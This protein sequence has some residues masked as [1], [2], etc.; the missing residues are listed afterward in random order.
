MARGAGMARPASSSVP[1]QTPRSRLTDL[2]VLEDAERVGDQHGGGEVRSDEVRGDGPVAD[3]HPPHREARLY[4]VRDPGLV[5]PD[6]AL[7]LVAE[8]HRE[9]RRGAGVADRQL[10]ARQD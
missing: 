4:L 1:A 5:E 7:V 10:V 6:D 8:P 2:D 9:D 3:V